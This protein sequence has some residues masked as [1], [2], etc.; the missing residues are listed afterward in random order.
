MCHERYRVKRPLLWHSVSSIG[1]FALAPP[2]VVGLLL[3]AGLLFV[4]TVESPVLTTGYVNFSAALLIPAFAIWW[5]AFVFR[6]RI[7]GDGR[8]LFYFLGRKGSVATTLALALLYWV[9]LVPFVLVARGA[10]GYSTTLV[11]LLLGRCLF[12]TSLAFCAAFV[13]QSSALALILALLFNMTAMM[14]LEAL[15]EALAPAPIYSTGQHSESIFLAYAVL[16][17]TLLTLGEVR[18]RHFTA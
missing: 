15:A 16:T 6:E 5:P 4:R 3:P 11:P 7:E 10:P 18:S 13:L 17:T 12:M 1:L 9:L 14:P 8:E 2:I